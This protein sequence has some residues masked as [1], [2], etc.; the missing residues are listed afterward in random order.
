MLVCTYYKR[1]CDF[2]AESVDIYIALLIQSLFS[3][4][5]K[6][7]RFLYFLSSDVNENE[8]EDDTYEDN[9]D[10]DEKEENE[11]DEDDENEDDEEDEDDGDEDEGDEGEEDEDDKDEDDKV[12]NDVYD[13]YHEYYEGEDKKAD[14]DKDNVDAVKDKD[15]NDKDGDLNFDKEAVEVVA[16][17]NTNFGNALFKVLAKAKPKENLIMSSFSV[18]TVLNMLLNGAKGRTASQ[19]KK[20]LTLIKERKRWVGN[21]DVVKNGF[22]DIVKNGFKDALTLLKTNESFTLNAANRIYHHV[23]YS[24]DK[25]YIQS[26]QEFFLAEPIGMDFKNQ[27]EQSRT[28]INQWVEGKTNRKIQD[29]IAKG[30]IDEDTK[31]VLVNAIYFKGDWQF[32]FDKSKTQKGDFHVTPN[33]KV[34]TDMMKSSGRYRVLWGIKDLKGADAL[35]LQYKGKR[36]SMIILLPAKQGPTCHGIFCRPNASEED[37]EDLEEAMSKVADLNSILVFERESNVDVTLPRFK[38]E[39]ELDL[40]EPLKQLGMTDMF[41]KIKADFS[42]MTGGTKN[43]LF[44]SK[45]KQKAFIEV[46]EE[47]AEAAAATFVA[48]SLFKSV[49]GIPEFR[50]NRPFMFLI[51]D[52]LTGM[53]LFSGHVTDPSK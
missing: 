50:C 48:V 1:F 47:G 32:K 19:L 24:F 29:L 26:T 4:H 2:S 7:L 49:S 45:I 6:G 43:P 9:K 51:R 38:L 11:E 10:E 23:L 15:D 30:D 42:G 12:G 25:S 37:L 40:K 34:Q 33:Q 16:N 36:L 5:F 22:E 20:G 8:D 52:N 3:N 31:L 41:K 14:D 28:A 17:A 18:S 35:D 46:N 44:V 21:S 13:D 39:S 27:T 53:I